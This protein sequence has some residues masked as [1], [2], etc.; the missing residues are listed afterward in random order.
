MLIMATNDNNDA[1]RITFILMVFSWNLKVYSRINIQIKNTSKA[2]YEIEK[3]SAPRYFSSGIRR[4]TYI[5][6]KLKL[7]KAV[8]KALFLVT[9]FINI[10]HNFKKIT[11]S[12]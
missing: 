4:P 6:K 5:K 2:L 10:D 12:L 8:S 3:L 9:L 1:I 7:I 11:Y